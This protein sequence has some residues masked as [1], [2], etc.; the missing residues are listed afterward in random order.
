MTLTSDDRKRLRRRVR[1][2]GQRADKIRGVLRG[3][4][5]ETGSMSSR[6]RSAAIVQLSAAVDA[7]ELTGEALVRWG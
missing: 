7:L 4:E 5:E 3:D 1:L 6:D 2:L